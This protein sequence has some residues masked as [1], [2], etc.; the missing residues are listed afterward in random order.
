MMVNFFKRNYCF[1][2]KPINYLGNHR[3]CYIHQLT[4]KNY[5]YFF[6]FISVFNFHLIGNL[7]KKV[8]KICLSAFSF[9]LFCFS[10]CFGAAV[11]VGNRAEKR[12]RG[13][14]NK[15]IRTK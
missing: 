11:L 3:I 15:Q 6:R 5:Y 8:S 7:E 13:D 9:F 4:D 1:S 12:F 2:T 10:F 14:E